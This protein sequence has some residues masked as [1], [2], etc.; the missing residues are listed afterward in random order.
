MRTNLVIREL[1][2]KEKQIQDF[3][4]D[5]FVIISDP[6][7]EN[8]KEY[9]SLLCEELDKVSRGEYSTGTPPDKVPNMENESKRTLQFINIWKCSEHFK[10]L[11]HSESL[12]RL[13]C[14]LGRW[15][16][17]RFAQGKQ[18]N[19]FHSFTLPH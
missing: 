3:A 16:G 14:K 5:G 18:N 17:A 13:V 6:I 4:R 10:R 7:F 19:S 11:V 15:E 2:V 8:A 12:G 9:V 1:D